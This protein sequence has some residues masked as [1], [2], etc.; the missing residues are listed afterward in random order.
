MISFSARSCSGRGPAVT[1]GNHPPPITKY[2]TDFPVFPRLF[3]PPRGE[4]R[5]IGVLTNRRREK[6]RLLGNLS[7]LRFCALRCCHAAKRAD[8]KSPK[9]SDSA[10]RPP[11]TSSP[12]AVSLR[13]RLSPFAARF[14]ALRC[15]HAVKRA[16]RSVAF[17]PSRA[18]LRGLRPHR[19]PSLQSKLPRSPLLR[20]SVKKTPRFL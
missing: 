5:K 1:A 15:C 18:G 10:K 6:R 4:T 11:G 13:S 3:S 14:C 12:L 16:G 7:G 2:S 20:A 19:S 17:P 8:R 9:P